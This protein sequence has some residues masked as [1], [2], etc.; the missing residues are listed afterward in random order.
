MKKLSLG[1]LITALFIFAS[2]IASH[3]DAAKNPTTIT[4]PKTEESAEINP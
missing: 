4:L 1:M 2:P 3:A